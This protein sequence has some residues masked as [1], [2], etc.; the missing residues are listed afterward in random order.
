MVTLCPAP[1][2]FTPEGTIKVSG[3]ESSAE[4]SCERL[5]EATFLGGYREI[6]WLNICSWNKKTK[7]RPQLITG[8]IQN[9]S[10]SLARDFSV[11]VIVIHAPTACRNKT[12]N[13]PGVRMSEKVCVYLRWSVFG[14]RGKGEWG[15]GYGGARSSGNRSW[16]FLAERQVPTPSHQL[17]WFSHTPRPDSGTQVSHGDLSESLHV[18]LFNLIWN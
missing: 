1:P 8:K 4:T 9:I 5:F 7:E 13:P 14:A 3:F 17:T 18:D 11:N 2:Q 15:S 16:G 10:V 6:M 12:L